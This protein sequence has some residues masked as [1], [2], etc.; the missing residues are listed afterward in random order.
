MADPPSRD[1]T[2]ETPAPENSGRWRLSMSSILSLSFGSLIAVALLLVLGFTIVGATR[3]T[4]NLLRERAELGISLIAKEVDTHLQAARN[5]ASFIAGAAF[6]FEPVGE[7]A[8]KGR[9][10]PVEVYR[11]LS[12]ED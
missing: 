7:M 11:L 10:G 5:Q 12:T 8:V 1:P 6:A 3:N 4:V 2:T 9:A